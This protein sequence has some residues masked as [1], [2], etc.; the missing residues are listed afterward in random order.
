[1]D[2]SNNI[3]YNPPKNIK[4]YVVCQLLPYLDNIHKLKKEI[5]VNYVMIKNLEESNDNYSKY[6]KECE[7]FYESQQAHKLEYLEKKA[8]IDRFHSRLSMLILGF[9][10]GVIFHFCTQTK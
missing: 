1:M 6:F 7:Y 5:E 3:S 4:E 8:E 9:I 10:G 2:S